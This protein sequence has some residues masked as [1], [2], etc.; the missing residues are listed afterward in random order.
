MITIAGLHVGRASL[1]KKVRLHRGRPFGDRLTEAGASAT[2]AG[3]IEVLPCIVE[4][5]ASHQSAI[6]DI[7]HANEL[8]LLTGAWDSTM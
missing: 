6:G 5:R 1:R 7:R 8:L 2:R 3:S 4:R